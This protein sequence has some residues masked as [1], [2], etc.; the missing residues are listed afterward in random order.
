MIFG[1]VV[2]VKIIVLQLLLVRQRNNNNGQMLL[3]RTPYWNFY[4]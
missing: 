1:D 4:L 2:Y 3:G